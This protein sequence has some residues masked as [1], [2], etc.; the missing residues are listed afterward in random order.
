MNLIENLKNYFSTV[1]KQEKAADTPE[2]ICPNCWG[3]GEWEGEYYKFKKGEDGNP[4]NATYNNFVQ[5][6]ARQ[7]DK[8][9][10]DE[11]SFVCE[12]CKIKVLH[13]LGSY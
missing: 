1:D 9:T 12:T 8:I 6:V 11:Y 3:R 10:I 4:S 7:L 2:G 5:D 13:K